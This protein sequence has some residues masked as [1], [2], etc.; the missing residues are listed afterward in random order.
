MPHY[1]RLFD[2][3]LPSSPHDEAAAEVLR[4]AWGIGE[5]PEVVAGGASRA[6][7]RVGGWWLTLAA[8][9]ERDVL[10]RETELLRRLEAEIAR[11]RVEWRV[12]AI[13]PTPEGADLVASS[14]GIW[15]LT[16][17]LP[18]GPPYPLLPE[19]YD[20]MAG[21]LA[22]VHRLLSALPTVAAVQPAGVVERAP[23]LLAA[24]LSEDFAPATDDPGERD[25]VAAVARWL[26]PRAGGLERLPRQLTHGDWAPANLVDAGER[27]GVVDWEMSRVDPVAMDLAQACS[28]LLMWSGLDEIA[29][30]VDALVARYAAE[31]RTPVTADEIRAAMALH[32]LGN[33]WHL[34]ERREG[35]ADLSAALARQ[36]SRLRAV[37]AFVGAL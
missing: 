1:V 34:R 24:S 3:P 37:G 18:G 36:P 13:V 8:D 11:R 27:W 10:R 7:W 32:W 2:D 9:A 29:R 16:A 21:L 20:R 15:R 5:R 33:Y 35:G 22:R 14:H 12:P 4:R 28:T 25:A 30:R 6:T 31:S 26:G 17:G 23:S 19:T